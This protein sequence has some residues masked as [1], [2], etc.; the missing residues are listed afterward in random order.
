MSAWRDRGAVEAAAEA[1]LASLD[2][3]GDPLK[4]ANVYDTAAALLESAAFDIADRIGASEVA[5]L[6]IYAA[7]LQRKADTLRAGDVVYGK[8]TVVSN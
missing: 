6:I 5:S 8:L 2:G 4:A 1:I 3:S 7:D